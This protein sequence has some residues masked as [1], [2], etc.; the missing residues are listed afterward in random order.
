MADKAKE[1]SN[2]EKLYGAP[3][4]YFWDRTVI[5]EENIKW[6][7]LRDIFSRKTEI[8]DSEAINY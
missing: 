1:N 5:S 4:A 6:A 3:H 8:M 7:K 2:I